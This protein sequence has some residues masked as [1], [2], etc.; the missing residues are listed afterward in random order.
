[1][2]APAKLLIIDDDIL[3]TDMLQDILPK[4]LF[5]PMISHSGTAGLETAQQWQPDVIMLDLIMPGMSG[6]ETCQAIRSF[7]QA[8]IL[9][10]S[11]VVDPGGVMQAL[12]AGANDY[13]LKPVPPGVLISHLKGLINPAILASDE[14]V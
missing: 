1:M 8:P 14:A 13:L 2:N 10:V 3:F 12:E 9:V 5:E 11:A 7:S 6:W 4:D